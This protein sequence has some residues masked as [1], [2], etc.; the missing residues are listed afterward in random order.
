M[1]TDDRFSILCVC[2][3]NICR[4]PAA[5]RLLAAALAPEVEV[6]SAGT[7][8]LVGQP[9]SP[10][11]D[12]LVAA[13]GADPTGF[14]AR[15]LTERVLQPVDLVLALT[16]AHRG[17]VVELWP[18]AVR[19][20]FTLKEL[21]RLLQEVDPALL[22]AA[23]VAERFRAAVPLVAARRRQV[24]EARLDD[25]VDPYRRPAEV[26][27]EAFADVQQAVAAIAAVV[28]PG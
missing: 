17:D 15:R 8:A 1:T 24:P 5:E 6:A 20:T 11:M 7:H 10:P 22:P 25:V 26:Y 9:I 3:G 18:K 19:R 23:G 14:A 4:S 16:R 27:Q 2:T 13:A 28:R 12:A 21:A